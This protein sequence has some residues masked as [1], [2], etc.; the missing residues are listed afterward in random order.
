MSKRLENI[1]ASLAD[2][3]FLPVD[4]EYEDY[5][6]TPLRIL[7]ILVFVYSLVI[8]LPPVI[9]EVKKSSIALPFIISILEDPIFWKRW[10][11]FIN[12]FLEIVF[13]LMIGGSIFSEWV[14]AH[15]KETIEKFEAAVEEAKKH[16]VDEARKSLVKS[17]ETYNSLLKGINIKNLIPRVYA[18]FKESRKIINMLVNDVA[19]INAKFLGTK[20]A[21]SFPGGSYGVFAFILFVALI[22]V[23]I[24]QFYL[25]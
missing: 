16:E 8:A 9:D 20:L 3:L 22:Q 21:V 6:T 7:V 1:V 4:F 5:L 14:A 18:L 12:F 17:I 10:L 13:F 2:K 11:P 19:K 25:Q 23:K 24:A 15:S